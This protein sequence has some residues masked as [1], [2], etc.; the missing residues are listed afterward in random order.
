[1]GPSIVMTILSLCLSVS[2]CVRLSLRPSVERVHSDQI[3]EIPV[4]IFTPYEEQRVLTGKNELKQLL[5]AKEQ[6][7]QQ[8][9]QCVGWLITK[10]E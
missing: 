9:L 8:N 5:C 3:E 2:V 4:Q 6:N 10:L 7:L 1:M